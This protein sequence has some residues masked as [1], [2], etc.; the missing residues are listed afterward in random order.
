MTNAITQWISDNRLFVAICA[1]FMGT[2]AFFLTIT[3]RMIEARASIEHQ[4]E[5]DVAHGK[6]H[7]VRKMGNASDDFSA[8]FLCSGIEGNSCKA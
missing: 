7:R 6:P 3:P 8:Y 2:I 5:E 1:V 4:I